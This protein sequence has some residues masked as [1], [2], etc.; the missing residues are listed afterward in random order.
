[1]SADNREGAGPSN[2][3]PA[4]TGTPAAPSAEGENVITSHGER[5]ARAY[6]A[7]I[8][9]PKRRQRLKTMDM[10]KVRISADMKVEIADPRHMPTTKM[11]LPPGGL[12]PP[13]PPQAEI[14]DPTSSPWTTS[15]GIDRSMLPSASL[16]PATPAPGTRPA[17][18]QS[19]QDED[20]GGRSIGIWIGVVL[21]AALLGGGAAYLLRGKV[22][23]NGQGAGVSSSAP[24]AVTVPTTP[25]AIP[26]PPVT[27]AQPSEPTP[28]EPTP[29]EPAPEEATTATPPTQAQPGIKPVTTARKPPTTKTTTPTPTAAPTPTTSSRP[30]LF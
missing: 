27:T 13:P 6:V 16:G 19:S 14:A 21:V 29:E 1:M 30:R 10:A 12:R 15:G 23:S 3:A 22:S 11:E 28:E 18:T 2:G 4:E 5:E 25:G 7:P 20:E 26:L 9:V 17:A 8:E 24:I